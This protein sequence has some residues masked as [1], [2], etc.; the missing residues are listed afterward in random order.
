MDKEKNK[1]RF[2]KVGIYTAFNLLFSV[3]LPLIL[4][5]IMALISLPYAKTGSIPNIIYILIFLILFILLIMNE[6]FIS[7]I[8]KK[9]LKEELNINNVAFYSALIKS[10]LCTILIYLL[11]VDGKTYNN[12]DELIIVIGLIPLFKLVS[13]LIATKFALKEKISVK[14][15]YIFAGYI[16][17]V[18]IGLTLCLPNSLNKFFYSG[19]F[20][21]V[22]LRNELVDNYNNNS[23]NSCEFNGAISYTH[24]FTE[25]ELEC[26][27]SLKLSSNFTT[28]DIE[29]FVNLEKLEI[30][31]INFKKDI[32]F[33]K[34]EKLIDLDIKNS[35]FLK[36][37]STMIPSVRDLSL[38]NTII[39]NKNLN[40]TNSNINNLYIDNI[41]IDNFSI[42]DNLKLE[43]IKIINSEINDFIFD[44]NPKIEIT[45][46][47]YNYYLNSYNELTLLSAPIDAIHIDKVENITFRNV[48][49]MKKILFA[50][51]ITFK[52]LNFENKKIYLENDEYLISKRNEITTDSYYGI[53]D[54]KTDNLTVKDVAGSYKKEIYD[55][56]KK[57]LTIK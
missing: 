14:K 45:D 2:K 17:L 34:N 6:Y 15:I 48:N 12:Y 25:E 43:N 35:T 13:Y 37:D 57:L 54:L 5:F 39:N 53:Y 8:T 23:R 42:I 11:S 55:N 21:S 56:E 30:E 44:N 28:K 19:Q 10:I 46:S 16:L 38:V 33:I 1:G 29:K 9:I 20:S 7:I 52:S 24:K 22:E 49:D 3:I 41:K 36:F 26:F 40:I 18:V 50:S 47:R 32:T 31:N 4:I 51:N 27:T